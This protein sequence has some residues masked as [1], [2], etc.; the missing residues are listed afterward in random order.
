M[1]VVGVRCCRARI[2]HTFSAWQVYFDRQ[3]GGMLGRF[4]GHRPSRVTNLFGALIGRAERELDIPREV[5]TRSLRSS[6]RLD[7][8]LDEKVNQFDEFLDL[9]SPPPR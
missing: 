1:N 7:G 5:I 3:T 6:I 9:V 2:E 4:I 8:R